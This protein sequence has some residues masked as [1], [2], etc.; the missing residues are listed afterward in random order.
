MPE[1]AGE[2][3]PPGGTL[4]EDP[5]RL[6]YDQVI[7]WSADGVPYQVPE[8]VLLFKAKYVR[9][10]DNADLAPTLPRLNPRQRT[11][12]ATAISRVYPGHAWLDGLAEG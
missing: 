4:V 3:I 7:A 1:E 6:P 11:W 12:L 5:I 8:I 2:A 9:D 10:K